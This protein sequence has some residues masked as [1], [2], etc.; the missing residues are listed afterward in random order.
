MGQLKNKSERPNIIQETFD[1][2]SRDQDI[3]EC[4]TRGQP[5]DIE[6]MK[7]FLQS[8]PKKYYF[9]ILAHAFLF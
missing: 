2:I 4:C 6:K 7:R 1:A 5:E 3:S 9:Y 8:D